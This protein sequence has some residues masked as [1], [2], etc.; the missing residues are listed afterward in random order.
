MGDFTKFMKPEHN[1]HFIRRDG[2]GNMCAEGKLTADLSEAWFAR[3][4]GSHL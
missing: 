3:D 4:S 1:G 2:A